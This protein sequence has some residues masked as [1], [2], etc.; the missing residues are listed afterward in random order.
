MLGEL[1]SVELIVGTT[2]HLPARAVDW[3]PRSTEMS[4]VTTKRRG[5]MFTRRRIMTSVADK[6]VQLYLSLQ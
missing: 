2:N 1:V 6:A 3:S 5:C 4:S